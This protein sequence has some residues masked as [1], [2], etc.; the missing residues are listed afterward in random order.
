MPALLSV[1]TAAEA[2]GISAPTV[3]R[4]VRAQTLAHIRIGDRVL[5]KPSDIED[6]LTVARVPA[7]G[8]ENA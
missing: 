8:A 3:R 5:F 1:K 2:L 4:M 7:K 6:F